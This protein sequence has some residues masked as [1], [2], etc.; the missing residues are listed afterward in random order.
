MPP[1]IAPQEEQIRGTNLTTRRIQLRNWPLEDH[2]N[3]W[4]RP[5]LKNVT[6]MNYCAANFLATCNRRYRNNLSNHY[7]LRYLNLTIQTNLF[8]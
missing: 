1:T 8:I 5:T 2:H 4:G 7:K 3:L 6:D